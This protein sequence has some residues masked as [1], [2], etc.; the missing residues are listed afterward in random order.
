MLGLGGHGLKHNDLDFDILWIN[1][2]CVYVCVQLV[3]FNRHRYII[4]IY[5]FYIYLDLFMRCAFGSD[6]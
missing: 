5:L 1:M 2:Q 3:F 6:R 4:Y